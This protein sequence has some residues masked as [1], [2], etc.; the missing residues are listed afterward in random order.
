MNSKTNSKNGTIYIRD[1]E[2]FKSRDIVKLGVTESL[3][4]RENTYITSEPIKGEFIMVIII[5][6]KILKDIDNL[7]QDHFYEYN[8]YNKGGGTEFYKRDIIEKVVPFIETLGIEYNVLSREDIDSIKSCYLSSYVPSILSG[9]SDPSDPSDPNDTS[10]PNLPQDLEQSIQNIEKY[11]MK[12]KPPTTANDQQMDVLDR[13]VEFFSKNDIGKIIW[14]CGL[15]KTFLSILI[16]QRL[17]FKKILF[18]VPSVNLQNQVKEEILKIYPNKRNILFVGGNEPDSTTDFEKIKRFLEIDF[19]E[20]PKFIISTYHSCHLLKNINFDFKIG[21]EAHHLVGT[22]EK[23]KGFR[24]FHKINSTKTLFMTAT[25]KIIEN[26]ND[27]F[28]QYSMDDE[29]KFGKL[30][31]SKSV[32][33]AIE[34][35]KI[36]DYNVLLLK[37]TEDE[38]DTIIRKLKI[39][40]SNKDLFLS[41][42]MSLKSIIDYKQ[43]SHIL[44]YTNSTESAELANEYINKIMKMKI[45][46][47]KQYINNIEIDI[48]TTEDEFSFLTPNT[49]INKINQRKNYYQ[50]ELEK[51]Q[52]IR[53]NLYNKA[54]HS[55][56]NKNFNDEI[57]KFKQSK[58]GIISCVY[59]F[60]EGFDLPKL[61][62]V[63][64]AENMMSEIRI[65]QY[66]LRPNRLDTNKP[67][68]KAFIILPYIDKDDWYENNSSFEKVRNVI[69]QMRNMDENI[70]QKMKYAKVSILKKDKKDEKERNDEY[71]DYD[72]DFLEEDDDELKK[73]KMILKYSKALKSKNTE[74]RNEYNLVRSINKSLNITSKNEYVNS[75]KK[76]SHYIEEPKK[77]FT[78]NGVWKNW[79]DFMGCDTTKYIQLYKDWVKFCKEENIKTPEQYVEACK[80]YE[81]LPKEPQFM[82]NSFNNI[83]SEFK[84]I[85]NIRKRY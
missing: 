25:E 45:L 50:S 63:C 79:Y 51:Y 62:G 68:K 32:M 47:L 72:D 35:K 21:D 31:D 30:I 44:L 15:G 76:H 67:D 8:V 18:G 14:S 61:N 2:W 7:L 1:N 43:L 11:R 13:I 26:K 52:S 34:N 37:N 24:L 84:Q 56:N 10:D 55:K 83:E 6:L 60:G 64:I 42:Y 9:V 57:E 3:K 80:V 4:D 75:K 70:E 82:Y 27:E 73:I 69:Y 28:I 66:L 17:K 41:C 53:Q 16:V 12:E 77:Y 74:A 22:H 29:T 23:E 33:W 38:V 20:E 59:I 71:Y 40:I 58:Y 85:Y 5:D 65:V 49:K 46:Y 78:N 39:K 19:D 54:L 81:I 48:E 36:T